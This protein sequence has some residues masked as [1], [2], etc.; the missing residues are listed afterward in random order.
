MRKIGS[1]EEL[2]SKRKRNTIIISLVMLGIMVIS[3]GGYAFITGIENQ[4]N[5][6]ANVSKIRG[7]E[8]RGGEWYF[9][10]EGQDIYLSSSPDDTANISVSLGYMNLDKYREKVLYVASDNNGMASEIGASLGKFASRAQAACY[11]NCSQNL[12]A[13]DCSNNLV[14]WH[15]SENSRVYSNQSCIFIDG[16]LKAVDAFLYKIFGIN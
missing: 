11:G 5:N 12:P 13:K 3:T 10:F 1:E 8:N 16:D 9:Q 15:E 14:V 7:V 2:Q 6:G 4:Q